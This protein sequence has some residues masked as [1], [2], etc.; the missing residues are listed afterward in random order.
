M[1]KKFIAITAAAIMLVS[2]AVAGITQTNVSYENIGLGDSACFATPTNV[3]TVCVEVVT[4][5][6]QVVTVHYLKEGKHLTVANE[7]FFNVENICVDVTSPEDY[8]SMVYWGHRYSDVWCLGDFQEVDVNNLN[9]VVGVPPYF[10]QPSGKVY[11]LNVGETEA[12][13][14]NKNGAVIQVVKNPAA[15]RQWAKNVFVV[16]VHGV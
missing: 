7:L 11:Q 8:G 10:T 6:P 1:M 2:S 14:F 13:V 9:R 3:P 12:F 4:E 5:K 15:N 16:I